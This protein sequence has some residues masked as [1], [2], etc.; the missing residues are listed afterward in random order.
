VLYVG[1][2]GNYIDR[3]GKVVLRSLV[4][5][6]FAEGLAVAALERKRGAPRNEAEPKDGYI[7]KTGQFRIRPRDWEPYQFSEGLA[8]VRAAD[9]DLW[10]FIDHTGKMV[11]EMR[12]EEAGD[13]HEGLARAG[14]GHVGFVNKTG[15]FVIRP[16]FF[17]VGNF[18]G[19]LASACVEEATSALHFKCGYIDKSGKW[20][21]QPV[22]IVILGDFHGELAYACTE[23]KC[24]YINRTGQFVWSTP[25][26]LE[27]GEAKY[28][29]SAMAG[30]SIMNDK[31]YKNYPCTIELRLF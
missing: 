12:Y 6:D 28:S 8:R 21:I 24:G 16:R 23:K 7:D 2:A 31:P 30:C 29:A 14:A 27:G 20:A 13:F 15:V 4:G 17:A 22:F 18:S 25:F 26:S 9:R 11:I 19:G 5:G 10:G 1:G 3:E